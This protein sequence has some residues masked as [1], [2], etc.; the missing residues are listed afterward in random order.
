MTHKNELEAIKAKLKG[1]T[2]QS[3]GYLENLATFIDNVNDL[4]LIAD[5]LQ[6]G[7]DERDKVIHDLTEESSAYRVGLGEGRSEFTL[8][9][10]EWIRREAQQGRD[11]WPDYLP[12]VIKKQ[13]EDLFDH[14]IPPSRHQEENEGLRVENEELKDELERLKKLLDA[15]ETFRWTWR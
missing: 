2:P 10:H 9:L 5:N 1:I 11:Y 13:C 3:L 14:L 12:D 6:R 4:V 8:V 15:R 7:V